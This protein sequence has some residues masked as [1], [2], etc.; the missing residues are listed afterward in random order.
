MEPPPGD[1]GAHGPFDEKAH[2][3]S[4]TWWISRHRDALAGAALAGA[5]A[6]AVGLAG[7][8]RR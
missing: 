8:A 1:P 4:L 6:A 3:R 2:D 5:A 7:R